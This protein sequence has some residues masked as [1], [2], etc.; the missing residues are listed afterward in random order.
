MLLTAALAISPSAPGGK[1]I[2]G[3]NTT[4]PRGARPRLTVTEGNIHSSCGEN[5]AIRSHLGIM[6]VTERI[7]TTCR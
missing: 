1:V 5:V 3:K 2:S 6:G 4:D 7:S